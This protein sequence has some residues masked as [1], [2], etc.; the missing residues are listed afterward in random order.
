MRPW[1]HVVNA[2]SGYLL[3]AEKLWDDPS[4]AGAWNFGPDAEDAVAV[5]TI[6]ERLSELWGTE[7]ERPV[8]GGRPAA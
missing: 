1:Q 8:P 2:N 4:L 6:V 7:I 3:L 5:R